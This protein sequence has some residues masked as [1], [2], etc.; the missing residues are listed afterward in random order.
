MM[1][2]VDLS[3][4][5][6]HGSEGYV[7]TAIKAED[8]EHNEQVHKAFRALANIEYKGDRTIALHA[9]LRNYED[10]GMFEAYWDNM[11]V[12]ETRVEELEAQFAQLDK[13]E[14]EDEESNGAF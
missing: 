9:L 3:K 11:K 6:D 1:T 10:R 14:Q 8:T 12:L 7:F 5:K 2:N 4:L 13:Q